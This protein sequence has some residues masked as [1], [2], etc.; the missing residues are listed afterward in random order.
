[1]RRVTSSL[2]ILGLAL[3]A[4][5]VLA[6]P[7]AADPP[8]A[9]VTAAQNGSTPGSIEAA[10][11]RLE[12]YRGKFVYLDFWA[13]WC[14][15]CQRSFPWLAHLEHLYGKSGLAVVAVNV[16]HERKAA[17]KF[18]DRHP[19]AFPVVWDPKGEIARTWNVEAM[20][21]GFLIS[22]EGEKLSEHR[23]FRDGDASA[24]EAEVAAAIA[25]QDREASTGAGS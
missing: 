9:A 11:F 3:W 13:S 16:D 12:D 1:M 17:R 21:S 25:Q 8:E 14:E 7:A 20:P 24:I 4:G 18:L 5:A 22:P 15:P 2:S 6:G 10:D 23:G 19:A